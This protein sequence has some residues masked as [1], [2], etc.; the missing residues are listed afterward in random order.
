MAQVPL[1]IGFLTPEYVTSTSVDGGL[2]NYLKK[3]AHALSALGHQVTII[4]LSDRNRRWQD[5][6]VAIQEVPWVNPPR[7]FS[8]VPGIRSLVPAIRLYLSA[9]RIAH[10]VLTIHRE[11]SISILQA[12]SFCSPGL[13]LCGNPHIPL[14]C[15]ISSYTPLLRSAYGRRRQFDELITDWMEAKQVAEAEAAFAPSRYIAKVFYKMEAV[16]A[17]VI[18]TPLESTNPSQDSSFYQSH[19][20]GQRYLLF[21]GT[22]SFIKGIGVIAEALPE[23]LKTHPDLKVVFIGRDDGIIGGIRAFQHVLNACPGMEARLFHHPAIPK[24]QLIPVIANSQG[25]LMPSVADN[26]PNACLEAQALG[27]IVVGSNDSSLEE[28]IENGLTGFLTENGSAES[29]KHA[30]SKLLSLTLAEKE[31]MRIAILEHIKGIREENRIGMLLSF[32]QNVLDK[33]PISS[34]AKP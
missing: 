18:P 25:V 1:H 8:K 16:R 34:R 14:V 33:F 6:P 21:F 17:A 2:A 15:R 22:L 23:I 24:S 9:R 3:T 7:L 32:Y 19:F 28:M 20:L 10:T 29:I 31:K 13:M 26:Y 11:R 27:T 12:S 4:V 5:G 30:V